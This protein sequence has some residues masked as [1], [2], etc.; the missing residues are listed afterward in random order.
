[1]NKYIQNI[2]KKIRRNILSDE[3]VRMEHITVLNILV[4]NHGK[5]IK[6]DDIYV[7]N[8]D[9]GAH[10]KH[11]SY[12][13]KRDNALRKIRQLIRDL[14]V[15][16]NIPILSSNKGYYLPS[17]HSDAVEF[18]ERFEKVV[19]AQRRSWNT[20]LYMLEDSLEVNS[21]IFKKINKLML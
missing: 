14:R 5:P 8:P 1:M 7:L 19:N 21:S 16:F 13:N 6:Q 12:N 17:S 9:I 15:N 20:T 11:I 4:K 3:R 2:Q 18:L 10:R